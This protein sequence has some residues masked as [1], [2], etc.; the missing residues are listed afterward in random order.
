MEVGCSALLPLRR[1]FFSSSSS[2]RLTWLLLGLK[3]LQMQNAEL[4]FEISLKAVSVLRYITDHVERYGP[5]L[6]DPGVD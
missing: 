4:E 6:V 5:V 3:E 1:L 2:S